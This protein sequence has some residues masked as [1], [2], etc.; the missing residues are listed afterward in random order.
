MPMSPIKYVGLISLVFTMVF[1]KS[2]DD[3]NYYESPPA[4]TKADRPFVSVYRPLDGKWRGAFYVLEDPA[5]GPASNMDLE[6]LS[7]SQ[8]QNDRL[9]TVETIEVEQ[10]YIS[11]SPFF[12]RVHIRDY[13]PES[14]K[15]EISIGVNK[16]QDGKMW[17]VVKK[18]DHTVTHEGSMRPP[19]TIIWQ[20]SQDNPQK[21]EYF[22]EEVTS[23]H[24]EIIGYGYYDEDDTALSPRLWFYGKYEKVRM[25][26]N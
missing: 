23:T 18:P 19:N 25:M 2:P 1:C 8:V 13:Y 7:L 10:E 21:I 12:Q 22:Q 5:P 3:V 4:V 9:E 15:E 20:S 11:E 24:Y 6:H 26:E 16:V 17:C 14:D